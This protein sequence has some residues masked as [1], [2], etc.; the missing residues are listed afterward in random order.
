ME[1]A[2]LSIQALSYPGYRLRAGSFPKHWSQDLSHPAGT[3][4]GQKAFPDQSIDLLLI[5]L[6]SLDHGGLIPPITVP[7][8]SKTFH[9]AQFSKQVTVSITVAIASAKMGTPIATSA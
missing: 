1:A 8:Y 3:H 6:V 7:G 5:V 4:P 2:H 9:P